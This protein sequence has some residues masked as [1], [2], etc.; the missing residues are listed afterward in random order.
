MISNEFNF[1]SVLCCPTKILVEHPFDGQGGHPNRRVKKQMFVKV[2]G[3]SSATLTINVES[4]HLGFVHR[5]QN[6][7]SLNPSACLMGFTSITLV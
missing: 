7:L 4:C 3:G 1:R 2:R 6:Q 5:L